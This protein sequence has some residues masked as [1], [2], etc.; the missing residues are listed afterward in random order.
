[1]AS[2]FYMPA[3]NKFALTFITVMPVL[4]GVVPGW[5]WKKD[6]LLKLKEE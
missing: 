4:S 6:R 3:Y 2:L 5:A 1:M